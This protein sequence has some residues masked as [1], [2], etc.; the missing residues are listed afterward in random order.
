MRAAESATAR[1]VKRARRLGAVVPHPFGGGIQQ[2]G[3]GFSVRQT[4]EQ[5]KKTGAFVMLPIVQVIDYSGNASDRLAALQSKKKLYVRLLEKRIFTR[6]EELFPFH[7]QRRD[8]AWI[9]TVNALRKGDKRFGI[10]W[11]QRHDGDGSRL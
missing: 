3:G 1:S 8:P 2:R 7:R 4:F 10:A 6:V 11:R 5:T 9:V